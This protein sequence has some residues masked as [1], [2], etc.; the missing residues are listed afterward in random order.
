VL[1]D[2]KEFQHSW[3]AAFSPTG[4]LLAVAGDKTVRVYETT[5]WQELTRFNGHDG[6]VSSVFFGPDDGTLVSASAEDG[7]ALVWSL[8]PPSER[9]PPDPA[10]LWADLA[11]DAPAAWRA[12]WSAARHPQVAVAL[13]RDKWPPRKLAA[14]EQVRRLIADL[15]HQDFAT[16]EAAEAGLVKIGRV[17]E[18]ELRKELTAK[19]SPEVKRRAERVLAR[20]SSSAPAACPA[21]EARELRAVW[22]L[23]LAGTPAARKLLDAWATERVGTR[24]CEEAAVQ[25]RP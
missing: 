23:K 1:K 3:S 17:V 25:Q 11:G 22:A 15:D 19:P 16:R 8:K 7:T 12:V 14:A 18:P 21:D 2:G 13:F 9:E 5:S 4:W 24:L 6:T 10:R 20:W